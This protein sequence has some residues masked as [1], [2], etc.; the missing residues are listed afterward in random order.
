MTKEA[1]KIFLSA[2]KEN[3][4]VTKL[5]IQGLWNEH[6][7]ESVHMK[8]CQKTQGVTLMLLEQQHWAKF[9]K[10]T[11]H[12]LTLT[13]EVWLV[14][15][16]NNFM[17]FIS[18]DSCRKQH[19]WCW[20]SSIEWIIENKFNPVVSFHGW[21]VFLFVNSNKRVI[22]KRTHLSFIENNIKGKGACAVFDMLKFNKTLR[23]LNLSRL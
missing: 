18:L 15:W 10:S 13:W 16:I 1:A 22:G 12:S 21:F 8:Q 3:I 5:G 17:S 20:C 2:F 19:W 7:A 9:W 4:T 23:E 11:L 14:I 6:E